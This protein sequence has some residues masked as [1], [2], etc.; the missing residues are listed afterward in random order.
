MKLTDLKQG[1]EISSIWNCEFF[2]Y[3]FETIKKALY[4][5]F[6][7]L[8]KKIFHYLNSIKQKSELK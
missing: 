6:Y 3:L 2:F 4:S 7:K 5:S 8:S 1:Q